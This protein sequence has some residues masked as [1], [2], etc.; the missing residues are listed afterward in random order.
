MKKSKNM[1]LKVKKLKEDA[2]LPTR[3]HNNDACFDLYA[4]KYERVVG[5]NK[6]LVSTGIAIE[7]PEGYFGKIYDR[8][9][10]GSTTPLMVVAGVIDSGYRGELKIVMA[11][12]SPYPY[13]VQPNDK[14]AQLAIHPIPNV[15]L[16]EVKELSPSERDE[17]GFGSSDQKK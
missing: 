12:V 1:I 11:N 16:E 14:I 2:I 8:S 6:T 7:I 4:S 13:D 17:K 15:T 3:T 9:G 5:E 10:V